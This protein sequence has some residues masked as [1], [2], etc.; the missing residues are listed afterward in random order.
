MDKSK[1]ARKKN[2]ISQILLTELNMILQNLKK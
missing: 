1:T 2:F